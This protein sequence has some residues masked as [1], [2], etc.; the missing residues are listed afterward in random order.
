MRLG[1]EIIDLMRFDGVR[2]RR[3]PEPS[4]RSPWCRIRPGAARVQIVFTVKMV[5]RAVLKELD[6]PNHAMNLI[7]ARQ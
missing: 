3:R 4:V 2:Q 5:E 6:P 1:A 7:A